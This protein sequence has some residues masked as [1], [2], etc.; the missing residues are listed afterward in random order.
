MT[1]WLCGT[2]SVYTVDSVHILMCLSCRLHAGEFVGFVMS[3]P[4]RALQTVVRS[5]VSHVFVHY[6]SN[7]MSP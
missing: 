1:L 3:V 5:Y 6:L 4:S 2:I 7:K